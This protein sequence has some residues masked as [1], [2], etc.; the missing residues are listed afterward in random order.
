MQR[1]TEIEK[2]E[3]DKKRSHLVIDKESSARIIKR[4]LWQNALKKSDRQ[5]ITH[6]NKTDV[7]LKNLEIDEE[8][9]VKKIKF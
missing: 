3:E 7:S 4:S 6:L 9:S 2:K 8:P 5:Q 1:L